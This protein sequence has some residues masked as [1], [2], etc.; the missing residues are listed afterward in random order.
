M[1]LCVRIWV[2]CVIS[3]GG[4]DRWINLI[5]LWTTTI[6]NSYFAASA[7][8]SMYSITT[9]EIGAIPNIESLSLHQSGNLFSFHL[10]E[11]LLVLSTL[12]PPPSLPS[13]LFLPLFF[14]FFH[15]FQKKF[16]SRLSSHDICVKCFAFILF[17]FFVLKALNHVSNK[18]KHM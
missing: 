6:F 17:P 11:H 9:F 12:P 18:T 7:C 5:N 8:C 15:Y 16:Q 4:S 3:A 10:I 2:F 1:Y 13:L 14:V